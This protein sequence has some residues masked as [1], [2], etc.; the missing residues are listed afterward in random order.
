MVSGIYVGSTSDDVKSAFSHERA[1]RMALGSLQTGRASRWREGLSG[2]LGNR[3]RARLLGALRPRFALAG[4]TKASVATCSFSLHMFCLVVEAVAELGVDL[5]GIIPVKSAEGQAV[6]QLH[7]AVC[8]V[9][10]G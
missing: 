6:I 1:K 4:R 7:A 5:A 10:G 2:R 3:T 8:D 9:Q